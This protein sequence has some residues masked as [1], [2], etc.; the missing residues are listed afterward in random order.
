[1]MTKRKPYVREVKADW[2]KRLG[3]YKFYMFRES[4]AVPAVWFSLVLIFGVFALRSPESWYGFVGFL[5]NPVV[6][7][8]NIITLIMA[9]VHTK[10]WFDLAPKAANIVVGTE[11]LSA[12]PIVMFFWGVTIVASLI[13]LAVA[14]I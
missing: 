10:T 8:I 13:I 1:M 14:L 6:M 5:A 9:L 7:V 3:F 2:W 11:K 4:T 12:K